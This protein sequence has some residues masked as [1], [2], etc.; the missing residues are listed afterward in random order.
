MF[1]RVALASEKRFFRI[2]AHIRKM[3]GVNPAFQ[4]E[5]GAGRSPRCIPRT[6]EATRNYVA[7]FYEQFHF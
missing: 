3:R 2:I 4:S 6:G 7:I 1:S 5:G